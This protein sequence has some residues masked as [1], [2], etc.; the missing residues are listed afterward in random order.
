MPFSRAWNIFSG[1]RLCV[2]LCWSPSW[3]INQL[4]KNSAWSETFY[5][6]SSFE[7]LPRNSDGKFSA[8]VSLRNRYS[9][10]PVLTKRIATSVVSDSNTLLT[11]KWHPQLRTLCPG[12]EPHPKIKDI[13]LCRIKKSEKIKRLE[14]DYNY[15]FLLWAHAYGLKWAILGI[16]SDN[17][18]RT[19]RIF[20]TNTN[21]KSWGTDTE[22]R[23]QT[24]SSDRNKFATDL[25][26]LGQ[27]VLLWDIMAVFCNNLLSV[28]ALWTSFIMAAK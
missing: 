3:I 25:E 5:S 6:A 23:R 20:S 8:M 2:A 24:F 10:W 11:C 4:N 27:T 17:I 13:N 19:Q 14:N 22:L 12:N 7:S 15:S 21:G 28:T 16:A 26:Y 18:H 9:R 1:F